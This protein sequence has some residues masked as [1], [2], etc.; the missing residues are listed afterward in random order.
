MKKFNP[1][2]DTSDLENEIDE[3]VYKLYNL[4]PEEIEVVKA[5]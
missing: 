5:S 2:V 4:T 1:Q 3:L